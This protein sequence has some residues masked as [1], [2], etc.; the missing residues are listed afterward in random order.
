LTQ[1]G[2]ARVLIAGAGIG[3]LTLALALLRRGIDVQVLEQAT[4]LGEVGAGVQLSPN[5]TRCLYSLGLQEA[6]ESVACVPEGKQVRLWS[7]GQRW[8]LFD[9]GQAALQGY[10]F[11]YLM[12]HRSDL[13]TVLIEAVRAL[14]PDAVRLGARCASFT[15]D[16]QSVRV[17]LE[18]GERVTGDALIAC[19]GVHSALRRGLGHEDR[20]AF[21]GCVAWRGLVAAHRL[22]ESM[23]ESVGTNWIGPGAHVITY[24]LRRGE[25]LNFVGIVERNGWER[26]SWTERG[27]QQECAADFAGWNDEVQ[28]L[29]GLL[30]APHKWAL[31]GRE[32]L[33]R[34]GEGRVTLLGDAA[35]PTL[36]F[37]AQGACM[38]I[39]D[40]LVLARCLGGNLAD[41]A[42]ALRRY[43][44][45]RIARTGRIVRGATE[46]GKRFHNPALA[47][48]QGAQAY[49]D[50]EWNETRTRERYHWLFAYDAVGMSLDEAFG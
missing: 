6:L 17:E 32:P 11:P 19:D 34:W 36:P 44:Q 10:G 38:A 2:S 13:H 18:G 22:P 5:A 37:L 29:I 35:H 48:A 49:V 25:L 47:D 7:T 24:P 27:S 23:R 41:A 8:R 42:E 30:D 46:A 16:A 21:T 12:A 45:L 20:P 1:S 9:L 4:T 43:E 50:R 3:G 28:T 14:N 31:M 33:T 15:Q 40:A 39:E 26:E